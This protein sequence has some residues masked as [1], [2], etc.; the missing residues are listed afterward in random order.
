MANEK[1]LRWFEENTPAMLD[2]IAD[3]VSVDSV[4][5]E[6]TEEAPYGKGALA[7]LRKAAD[8]LKKCGFE[9]V[10]EEN[11]VLTA[12]FGPG[13][14]RLCI[15]AHV[16]VVPAGDGWTVTEP[17]KCAV[18]DGVLYGRGVA[19]DKG[20]AV[21]AVYAMK[22]VKDLGMPLSHGV[23]LVLG[24]C[25]ERDMDDV[26]WYFSRHKAPPM[27]FSPDSNYPIVNTEKGRLL[28][29][30]TAELEQNGAAKIISIAGGTVV[31]AVPADAE[32]VI[33]GVTEEEL[34]AAEAFDHEGVDFEF[35]AAENGIVVR[36]RGM[37]AHAAYAD[38]G[39]N[40][41]AALLGLLARMPYSGGAWDAVRALGEALPFGDVWG[42]VCGAACADD[43]A[44]PMTMNLGLI[45]LNETALDA[46]IDCRT[47]LNADAEAVCAA[48]D[49][50]LGGAAYARILDFKGPHHVPAE[51]E[52][53]SE[54]LSIYEEYTGLKGECA[55]TGGLTYVHDIEGGVAFGCEF[56]GRE[57]HI[58]EPDECIPVQDLVVS[59]QM[60]TEAIA[61]LCK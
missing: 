21:A 46:K 44:G 47:S 60:F 15:L 56:P 27:V 52:M 19:D 22:A 37:A 57:T 8:I 3:L 20:P 18:K 45:S 35:E 6:P 31:N 34:R 17:F 12:D 61:R 4:W 1:I 39:R 59:A 29:G 10:I 54:L 40:A 24:S 14:P 23:R 16:D 49:E 50:K 36:T 13:E 32:A 43:I 51:S 38:C 11:R 58:H 53:V 9:P 25:E 5:S 30:V 42:R 48:L 28:L 26:K 41:A 33:C 7:A 55:A 2:D